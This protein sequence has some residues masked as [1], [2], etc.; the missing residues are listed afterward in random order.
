MVVPPLGW[1]CPVVYWLAQYCIG[2]LLFLFLVRLLRFLLLR[3]LRPTPFLRVIVESP[4]LEYESNSRPDYADVSHV[5]HVRFDPVNSAAPARV[6][7]SAMALADK[8][9]DNTLCPP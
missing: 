6:T 4:R 9:R 1:S 5:S 2:L 8:C 7:L 3:R